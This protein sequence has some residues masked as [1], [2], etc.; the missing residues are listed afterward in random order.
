MMNSYYKM[1]NFTVSW[2]LQG[3]GNT[4]RLQKGTT[5]GPDFECDI[6][7]HN[8]D[9][10]PHENK[11]CKV[12]IDPLTNFVIFRR[13]AEG[14][15]VVQNGEVV[16]TEIFYA[17]HSDILEIGQSDFILIRKRIFNPKHEN[18]QMHTVSSTTSHEN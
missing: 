13:I 11:I 12:E 10:E 3:G 8:Q 16:D 7:V 6:G 17:F 9:D 15:R 4:Y 2:F 18:L 1:S 5:I 14:V